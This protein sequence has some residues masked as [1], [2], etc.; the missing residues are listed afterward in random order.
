MREKK[1]LICYRLVRLGK[2]TDKRVAENKRSDEN[3]HIR[4]VKDTCSEIANSDTQK[5]SDSA[6][7]QEP[8]KKITRTTADYCGQDY[9]VTSC[10]VFINK[11]IYQAAEKKSRNADI[12]E[13]KLYFFRK[14]ADN[15]K[16][17]TMIFN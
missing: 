11:K 9:V 6:I 13:E 12:Q 14:L 8:V 2:S 5:I 7:M 4:K 3:I 17:P 15:T 16:K 10:A 1:I